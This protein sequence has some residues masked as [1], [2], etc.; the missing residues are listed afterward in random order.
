MPHDG[1]A[2]ANFVLDH[3]D[4]VG[5]EVTN[6]KLQK[7]VY[8]CHVWSWIELRKPLIRHRFEAWRNGPVL[9]YLYRDFKELGSSP[10]NTRALALDPETGARKPATYEF[11][12]VTKELLERVLGFYGRLG[13]HMLVTLTHAKD[14]PWHK[15][16]HHKDRV[17]PGMKIS[18]TDIRHFYERIPAPIPIQ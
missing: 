10:I 8:F 4:R 6:L 13:T 7:L 18:D 16:W 3:A 17:R 5:W 14:G 15:V 12:P 11:E 1:R 9:P 2:I